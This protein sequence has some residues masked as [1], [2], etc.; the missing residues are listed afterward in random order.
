MALLKSWMGSDPDFAKSIFEMIEKLP[1][2]LKEVNEIVLKVEEIDL[3]RKIEDYI[4]RKYKGETNSLTNSEKGGNPNVTPATQNN[5][6]IKYR[7]ITKYKKGT[8]LHTDAGNVTVTSDSTRDY[9]PNKAATDTVPWLKKIK[10][11]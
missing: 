8:V 5:T 3:K 2:R 4:K 6:P 7:G 10:T 1:D 11:N 9:T